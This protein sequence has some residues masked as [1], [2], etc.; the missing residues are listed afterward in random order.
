MLLEETKADEST[1]T[2]TETTET[3]PVEKSEPKVEK[4]EEKTSNAE[5][6]E[7]AEKALE[8]PADKSTEETE[9]PSEP[10]A[11]AEETEEE[12]TSAEETSEPTAEISDEKDTKDTAGLSEFIDKEEETEE[13]TE[14]K[15]D[16]KQKRIDKL[17]AKTY[18][19]EAELAKL[20]VDKPKTEDSATK[21]EQVYTEAQLD[22]AEKGAID[23]GDHDL[24]ILINKERMKNVKRELRKEYQD[25]L[26]S[27]K[28]N[29]TR[30]ATEWNQVK[31]SYQY[32]AAPNA[33][34][35]Y[36]GASEELNINDNNS[37]L[38]RLANMLYIGSDDELA[39][40]F[41]TARNYK[42]PGGQTQAVSDALNLILAKR[43]GK[44]SDSKETKKLRKRLTKAKRKTSLVSPGVEKTD[45]AAPKKSKTAK[46]TLEDEISERKKL[47][48]ERSGGL[49]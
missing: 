30:I 4:R 45:K 22:K 47:Q 36:P 23:D 5:A 17:T 9:E 24:Q 21:G 19:L 34:E 16:G 20:R 38:V 28:A 42:Q 7:I 31:S 39:K 3:K 40:I 29:E 14:T 26:N 11:E 27:M 43:G 8:K 49:Y 10:L 15:I 37:A 33:P 44:K 18:Q 1:G 41:G 12:E 13:G 6:R 35:L 25:N 46:A 32:L 48:A 2:A